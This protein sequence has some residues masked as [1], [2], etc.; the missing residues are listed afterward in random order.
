MSFS[1]PKGVT[2]RAGIL[3]PDSFE[4]EMFF[5]AQWLR[6]FQTSAA[7]TL[8]RIFEICEEAAFTSFHALLGVV[9]LMKRASMQRVIDLH[10]LASIVG[11]DGSFLPSSS[12][13]PARLRASLASLL[14]FLA[15]SHIVK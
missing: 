11:L 3:L 14:P 2:F 6:S 15:R 12:S 7:E 9:D 4:I 1:S 5:V 10:V 8:V 13:N